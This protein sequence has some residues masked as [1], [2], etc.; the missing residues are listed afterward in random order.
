M[1]STGLQVPERA[2]FSDVWI[3]YLRVWVISDRE[4][5][6]VVMMDK[7]KGRAANGPR[8][9]GRWTKC[10]RA[11]GV[12]SPQFSSA[13]RVLAVFS[14][15]PLRAGYGLTFYQFSDPSRQRGPLFPRS[16][17]QTLV[18]GSPTLSLTHHIFILK[19]I[20]ESL[21]GLIQVQS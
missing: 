10:L 4:P 5:T 9:Q 14:R 7:T 1:V 18:V 2:E 11:D 12:S 17:S 19:P 13:F 15:I 21:L 16:S 6:Q 20:T 8:F 3:F